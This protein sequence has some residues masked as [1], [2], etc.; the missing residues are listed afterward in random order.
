[1][2]KILCVTN[3]RLCREDFFCRLEKI[4]RERPGG[5]ILREKDLCEEA[6]EA[7]A[8]QVL[9]LCEAYRVPCILHGCPGAARKLNHKA[10]HLPMP[11]LRGLSWEDKSFFEVLG[12]SCH[13]VEEAREAENLGCTY[14]T[15]GHIFATDCKMGLPGRGVEFLR[16]VCRTV[17]VPVYA[18]GGIEAGRIPAVREAGA[19]GA[20]LMSSLMVTEDFGIL[21][22]NEAEYGR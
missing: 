14:L 13:S 12:A 16:E 17:S 7:L 19:A 2:F 11:V 21:K 3:R 5:L 18:I 9:A 1:M 22:E 8:G 4:L 15:A 6:Y 10:I 20:C